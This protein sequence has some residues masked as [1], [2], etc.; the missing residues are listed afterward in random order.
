MKKGW[1]HSEKQKY[2]RQD[3]KTRNKILAKFKLVV[4]TSPGKSF[5][6]ALIFTYRFKDMN[7][8]M[9]SMLLRSCIRPHPLR[10][11]KTADDDR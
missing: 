11:N 7:K 8:V 3:Y 9:H 10:D 1:R 4:L 2:N 6:K 5:V